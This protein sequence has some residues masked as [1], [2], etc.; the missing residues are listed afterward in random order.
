M[1]SAVSLTKSSGMYW[2]AKPSPEPVMAFVNVAT[3]TCTKQHTTRF[4]P[5]LKFLPHTPWLFVML[6]L[7]LT[8]T[9]LFPTVCTCMCMYT[10]SIRT[11]IYVYV[12]YN[13]TFNTSTVLQLM[14]LGVAAL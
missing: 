4:I 7:M 14:N 8:P 11:G 6:L 1:I 5:N 2:I 9:M 10:N 3:F 12:Q 13:Y